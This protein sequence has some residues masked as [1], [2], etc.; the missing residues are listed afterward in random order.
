MAE[1]VAVR[2]ADN[3]VAESGWDR[4]FLAADLSW[5]RDE[6]FDMEL[7]GFPEDE[8]DAI[9]AEAAATPEGATDPDAVPEPPERRPPHGATCGVVGGTCSYAATP[10]GNA[11]CRRFWATYAPPNCDGPPVRRG[12]PPRVAERDGDRPGGEG[13]AGRDGEGGEGPRGQ[14]PG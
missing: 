10:P 6:E 1:K 9:L 14:G 8:I 12:L 4:E 13:P 7:V 5:L 11:T 2:I 3:K